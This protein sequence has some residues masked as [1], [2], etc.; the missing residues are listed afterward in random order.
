[1]FTIPKVYCNTRS[2]IELTVQFMAYLPD[3]Y[4]IHHIQASSSY[5]IL[6]PTRETFKPCS[7]SESSLSITYHFCLAGDT[8]V[9]MYFCDSGTKSRE[10]TQPD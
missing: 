3:T 10:T 8:R 2:K 7:Y 4:L 9:L 5:L 6:Q 1:M